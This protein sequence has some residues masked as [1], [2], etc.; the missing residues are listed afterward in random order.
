[1]S[2]QLS[3]AEQDEILA[4]HGIT[5]V[6][7]DELV[8]FDGLDFTVYKLITK[9]PGGPGIA[10]ANRKARRAARA[11]AKRKAQPV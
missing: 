11:A 9:A 8:V 1:M 10:A 7:S 3:R 2:R 4:Q 6:E 5:S